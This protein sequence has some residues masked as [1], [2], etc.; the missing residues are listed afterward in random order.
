[1]PVEDAR[2]GETSSSVQRKTNKVTWEFASAVITKLLSGTAQQRAEAVLYLNFTDYT[3]L[4]K[5]CPK[6]MIGQDTICGVEVK[7]TF[8]CP[9]GKY[10]LIRR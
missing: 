7:P 2:L 1:M 4:K 9:A 3:E 6:S 5:M 10:Y 8:K